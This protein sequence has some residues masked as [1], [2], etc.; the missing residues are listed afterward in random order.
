MIKLKSLIKESILCNLTNRN[1]M[2]FAI[3]NLSKSGKI[4]AENK[5]KK[6]IMEHRATPKDLEGLLHDM[7]IGTEW[8]GKVFLVGGFVRDELMG[9][10]PKDADVVVQKYQGGVEFTTW[11][12]KKLGIY[13]EGSNPVIYPTFGTANLR[14]DGVVHNGIDFT[15]ESVDAVMFRKEQYHDTNTRK[16]TVQYTDSIEIDASRRDMTFNALYKDIATGKVLDPSGRE[17]PI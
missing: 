1:G 6:L 10:A 5:Q 11:L 8:A 16:P 7:I 4:L 17:S 15:G 2:K 14:L 3:D 9:K 12:G 13:K